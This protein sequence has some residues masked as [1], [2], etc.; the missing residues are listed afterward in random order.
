MEAFILQYKPEFLW[1]NNE[2]NY[3]KFAP[4]ITDKSLV[5][6]VSWIVGTVELRSFLIQ[7]LN[8]IKVGQLEYA[9]IL[10]INSKEDIYIS[11]LIVFFPGEMDKK[12][13]LGRSKK[14]R[15]QKDAI[16]RYERE[17]KMINTYVLTFS[18][19]G[20]CLLFHVTQAHFRRLFRLQHDGG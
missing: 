14:S 7:A 13:K 2:A 18:A 9:G 17:Y 5:L 3:Y 12:G 15:L 16:S 10:K 19:G 20:I 8:T 6:K 1:G 11:Y 4:G